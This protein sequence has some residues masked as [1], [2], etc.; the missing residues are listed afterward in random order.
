MRAGRRTDRARLRTAPGSRARIRTAT[1]P[2]RRSPAR[3]R[4][5]RSCTRRLRTSH[6]SRGRAGAP[7]KG[8]SR[9]LGPRSSGSQQRSPRRRRPVRL[10]VEVVDRLAAEVVEAEELLV[11]RPAPRDHAD[12][13]ELARSLCIDVAEAAEEGGSAGKMPL[14]RSAWYESASSNAC[15]RP[16]RARARARARWDSSAVSVRSGRSSRRRSRDARPTRRG[17]PR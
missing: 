11:L 7:R 14:S 16:D 12:G 3:T 17:A 9:T 1:R 15:T 13:V 10:L 2:R 8:T 4:A 6:A 5:S